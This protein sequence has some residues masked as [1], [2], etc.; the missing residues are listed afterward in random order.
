[1]TFDEIGLLWLLGAMGITIGF[2]AIFGGL[3]DKK[4]IVTKVYIGLVAVWTGCCAA[5]F[6]LTRHAHG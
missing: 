1:M 5:V 6:F 2:Y 4:D 3:P